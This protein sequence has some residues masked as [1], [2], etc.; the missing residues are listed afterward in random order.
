M[1]NTEIT[2]ASMGG[3]NNYCVNPEPIISAIIDFI[4]GLRSRRQINNIS[5]V[6]R[7]YSSNLDI[8]KE[9]L[10]DKEFFIKTPIYLEDLL[11]ILNKVK[12]E[13]SEEKRKLFAD[14]L[15][16]CRHPDNLE[17]GNK[18]IF[19]RLIEQ[20]DYLAVM[21]LHSLTQYQSEKGIVERIIQDTNNNYETDEILVHL[22]NLES[23]GLVEKISAEELEKLSKRGGNRKLRNPKDVHLYR[24]NR[25]GTSLCNFITKGVVL[26]TSSTDHPFTNK[27]NKESLS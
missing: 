26:N 22:W 18:A 16:A 5:E 13:E 1:A 14:F 7:I 27:K 10:I 2:N 19:F 3:I 24:N 9:A 21:I 25:L 23:L 20:L 8:M 12:N 6:L 11:S 15:S 4:K 17:C